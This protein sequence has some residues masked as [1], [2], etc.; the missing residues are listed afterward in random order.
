M[1]SFKFQVF[2]RHLGFFP[3]LW[4]VYLSMPIYQLASNETGWKLYIGYFMVGLFLLTYRQL[5]FA[6]G[7]RSFFPWLLLQM[8]IIF[9]FCMGY[10]STYLFMGF[11]TANFIGWYTDNR[12]FRT[13]F[14]LFVLVETVPLLYHLNQIWNPDLLYTLPFLVIM[15]LSPFGIRSMNR[16]QKLEQ[17]LAQ[18]N[19]QIH[20]L[21]KGEE[22]MRIARDL[23]D[24]LGHTLSLITLKS[25]LVEKLVGVNAE[26]A[27]LEARE[28]QNTSRAALRQVRELV[29]DMRTATLTE[30][31]REARIILQSADIELTHEGS[32]RYKGIPDTAHNILSLCLREAVTNVVK[33]SEASRCHVSFDQS[34]REWRLSVKDNGIGVSSDTDGQATKEKNGLKGMVERLALVSGTMKITAEEGTLLTVR[35]PIVI[36]NRKGV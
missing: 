13:A 14:V 26:Q 23:H 7:K 35:V 11:F 22:R 24:T 8:L 32:P 4:L 17:E 16:R 9:I 34:E 20:N 1:K 21:I 25:Q 19:E 12:K 30:E 31:L 10:G 3:Y 36:T 5:Y 33:H 29:S 6:E 18:A 2:P 15:M 27:R 28:I